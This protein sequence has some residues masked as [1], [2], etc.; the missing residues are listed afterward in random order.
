MKSKNIL[1]LTVII[2]VLLVLPLPALSHEV[3]EEHNI[4]IITTEVSYADYAVASVVS[5][6]IGAPI[7]L[8]KLNKV[9]N[10]ILQKLKQDNIT[11]VYIIGGPAVV[12]EESEQLLKSNGIE[13]V[14]IFGLTRYGTAAEVAK[15]FWVEGSSKAVIVWDNPDHDLGR[16]DF[17]SSRFVSLASQ[18]AAKDE[19]P[20]LLIPKNKLPLETKETLE[21]LGVKEVKLVGNVGKEVEDELNSMGIEVERI[22]KNDDEKELENKTLEETKKNES[23]PIVIAA[24]ANWQDGFAVRAHPKGVAILVFSENEIS[25]VIEKVNLILLERN[26]SKI[27]VVGKPELAQKIYNALVQAGIDK[28]VEVIFASG[29]HFE[30]LEKVKERIEKELE[31]SKEKFE[32]I[33]ERI[34]KSTK[35]LDRIKGEC[36]E[37]ILKVN[38]TSTENLTSVEKAR[39]NLIVELANACLNSNNVKDAIELLNDARG[40]LKKFLWKSLAVENDEKLKEVEQEKVIRS[41]IVEKIKVIE[42]N[43]K[44]VEECIKMK[45]SIEEL[46]RVLIGCLTPIVGSVPNISKIDDWKCREL[47]E[48]VRELWVEFSKK[49]VE[50][51][52]VPINET[53]VPISKRPVPTPISPT[54]ETPVAEVQEVKIEMIAKQWEFVPNV[55]N[56]KKGSKVILLVKS[57]DVSHGIAIP[58]YNIN[59]PLPPNEIKRIEFVADKA[60]EFPFFCSIY[61]GAG[62]GG[63]TGKLIVSE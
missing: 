40:E 13:V 25:A 60:G 49:C 18:L 26:V 36:R 27:L 5:A 50:I 33:V 29:K 56:V 52:P 1:A 42:E 4:A 10:E 62:H 51:K 48:K 21:L 20:L 23:L 35:H 24:V 43:V 15:Y 22:A 14:R 7:F 45:S 32:K 54:Q 16:A 41:K 58:D 11:R 6:K 61:C 30:I 55:I 47:E 9:D 2:S 57:T 38:E 3:V 59:V 44:D 34:E 8:T 31:K 63:M 37:V 12:D 53:P 19:I 46:R 28:K 17:K 39:L